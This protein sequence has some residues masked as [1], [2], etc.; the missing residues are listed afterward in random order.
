M[1]EKKRVTMPSKLKKQTQLFFILVLIL[2]IYIPGCRQGTKDQSM[3]SPE[4]LGVQANLVFLYYKDLPAAQRFYQE[5]IGLSLVLDYGFAKVYQISQTSFVGLV[6]EAEGMHSASEPKTVTLA[7]VT[8][9]I[10]GWYEY[11]KE[12]EVR[13]HRPLE[14]GSR[15]PIRG[16]VAYDPEGYFLEFETFLA[17]PQNEKIINLLERSDAL[18]LEVN[19]AL[20]RPEELG[21]QANI[22][23]LYYKDL[24]KAQQFYEENLGLELLVDQGFAKVYFASPTFFVGLVDEKKGMHRFSEEKAVTVSFIS[25]QIDDWYQWLTDKGLEMRET[26]STSERIPVRAF[27]TCDVGGYFLEF[28]RFLADEKNDK[29]LGLLKN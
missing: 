16:F 5:I 6:D 15:I 19:Q 28:D 3:E 13:M 29:I 23:W 12:K 10:D 22:S 2:G 27:V 1:E 18:Y 9:E 8:D 14:S 24:E 4:K 21:V 26:L 11:L 25:E 17:H 7:F 20:S